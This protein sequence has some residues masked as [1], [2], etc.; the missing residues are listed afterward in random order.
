[1]SPPNQTVMAPDAGGHWLVFGGTFDP[2]HRGHLQLVHDMKQQ[3]DAC[4][5]I[6]APT[7]VPPHRL[8]NSLV[9]SFEART[10]MLRLATQ[11]LT[12][13]FL[14]TIEAELAV[15]NYTINLLRK[16]KRRYS[17]CQF[18]LLM[19]ADQLKLFTEWHQWE[20]ILSEVKLLVGSRPSHSPEVPSEIPADRIDILQTSLLDISSTDVRDKVSSGCALDDLAC[21]V[22][23]KVAEYIVKEKLYV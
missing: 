11:Q 16:L 12:Y 2:V 21:L 1:M 15:P 23:D 18:S 7:N 5:V 6:V 14:S 19:G 17:S 3:S 4:G 8:Q 13:I 10:A 20:Q 22:P 9:A